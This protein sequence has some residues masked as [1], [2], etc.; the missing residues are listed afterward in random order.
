LPSCFPNGVA[1][2]VGEPVKALDAAAAALH[3]P[4]IDIAFFDTRMPPD[5]ASMMRAARRIAASFG[6]STAARVRFH[7]IL[8]KQAILLPRFQKRLPGFRLTPLDLPARGQCLYDGMRRLSHGPGPQYLYKPLLHY[9]M[10]TDVRRLVVL[11]TDVVMLRDVAE[12]YDEFDRFGMAL[13][14]IAR[15]QSQLY[16]PL[17]GA[18]GGVQLLDLEKMRASAEY[19]GLLDKHATGKDGRRIGYLGD[20]TL[21]TYLLAERPDLL[22][23]LPCEWNRQISAHF[24]FH[25]ATVHECPRRCGILHAN[26][27]P[28]KCIAW[29]MQANPSCSEWKAFAEALAEP[30]SATHKCPKAQRS[31]R[32]KFKPALYR[33]FADCCTPDGL[34]F[35]AYGSRTLAEAEAQKAQALLRPR[36]KKRTSKL[37]SR[38]NTS[39]CFLI[40]WLLACWQVSQGRH[41][42]NRHQGQ[43][44]LSL[45][46]GVRQ[47]RVTTRSR[48]PERGL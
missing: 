26:F 21:Y 8:N 38:N 18:N 32:L 48:L 24:G 43:F 11:D 7:A 2:A 9:I 27:G 47:R 10:P 13:L 29:S 42:R 6:N 46:P 20:Q 36:G 12:L 15:E 19:N 23:W 22:A 28:F 5:T 40:L 33:F 44:I 16:A 30:L 17:T 34:V 14:A 1:Q 37:F 35:D 39:T 25:N 4:P 31:E 41:E 3:A 45:L